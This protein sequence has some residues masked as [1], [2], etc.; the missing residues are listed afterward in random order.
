MGCILI[1]ASLWLERKQDDGAGKSRLESGAPTGGVRVLESDADAVASG[2]SDH[3]F[4]L[5]ADGIVHQAAT[6]RPEGAEI[7]IWEWRFL[8]GERSSGGARGARSR[9]VHHVDEN[10]EGVWTKKEGRKSRKGTHRKEGNGLA[11]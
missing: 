5:V 10:A 1:A 11:Y 4:G 3:L 9:A 7:G 2:I 8:T 6:R